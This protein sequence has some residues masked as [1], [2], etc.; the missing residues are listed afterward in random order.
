MEKVTRANSL[1]LIESIKAV[2]FHATD[3]CESFCPIQYQRIRE[4]KRLTTN[5][6]GVFIIVERYP[7][8][9]RILEGETKVL[10][11]HPNHLVQFRF[12]KRISLAGKC[13]DSFREYDVGQ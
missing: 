6:L 13:P 12:T 9:L 2:E 11:Q 8:H 5:G 4:I 7:N 10:N 3:L 1:C